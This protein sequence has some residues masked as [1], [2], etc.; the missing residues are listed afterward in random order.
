MT[1]CKQSCPVGQCL[2]KMIFNNNFQ[3]KIRHWLRIMN[4]NIKGCSERPVRLSWGRCHISSQL[5][6][7]RQPVTPLT[8]DCFKVSEP[9]S[10]K[11]ISRFL[12]T[13]CFRVSW[14]VRLLY[15]GLSLLQQWLRLRL[16][17]APEQRL[18][19]I[20]IFI[21]LSVWYDNVL[22][23]KFPLKTSIAT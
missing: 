5:H 16:L 23:D 9:Q 1:I 2:Q 4:P 15:L 10:V 17:Q 13:D 20:N 11:S 8:T 21:A 12:T 6:R 3:N 19:I 7:L 22:N 18:D 14:E